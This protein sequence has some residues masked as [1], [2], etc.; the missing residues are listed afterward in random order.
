MWTIDSRRDRIEVLRVGD[1]PAR[2]GPGIQASSDD[3]PARMT[4]VYL[5]PPRS[6]WDGF[7]LSVTRGLG[8][9]PLNPDGTPWRHKRSES[10]AD[11]SVAPTGLARERML[12]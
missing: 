2:E 1:W 5:N 7:G 11:G 8:T 9:V 10:P 12:I 4:L 6:E 3:R